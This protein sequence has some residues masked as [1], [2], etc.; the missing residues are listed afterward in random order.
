LSGGFFGNS[1]PED[2]GNI[3]I[4]HHLEYNE[5]KTLFSGIDISQYFHGLDAGVFLALLLELAF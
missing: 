2:L 4:G 3:L 5:L 1:D